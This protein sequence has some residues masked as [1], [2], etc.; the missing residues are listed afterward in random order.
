LKP[1]KGR[2]LIKKTAEDLNLPEAL[3]QDV[4]DFYYSQVT[5]KIEGLKHTT[6]LLHGLGTLRM[7]RVKLKRDIEGLK[8][9]LSSNDQED[10]KKVIKYNLTK[11]RIQQKEEALKICNTYYEPIYEK[12]NKNLEVK[13]SNPGRDKE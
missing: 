4:V 11:E 10:F 6:L 1:T 13:R 7:S 12:R 3:V 2:T 9:L 8:K 5:K